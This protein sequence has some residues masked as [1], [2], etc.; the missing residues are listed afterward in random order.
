MLSEQE[1]GRL[2]PA[3][4]G[5]GQ[6]R[7]AGASALYG[8]PLSFDTLALYYNK[9]NFSAAPPADTTALLTVARGLT[10]TAS[11]PPTWGLALNLGLDRTIGYLYAFGGRVFDTQSSLVLGSDGRAGA[12]AWLRWLL[13]LQDDKRILASTD[14]ISVDSALMTRQALMTIDWAHALGVYRELWPE[15]LGVAAL[16]RLSAA[17]Q[18]PQAYVQS[19]VIVLNA[20]ASAAERQAAVA[21][22]R[23]L[24]DS[25][26]QADLLRAGRQPALGSLNL[27]TVAGLAPELRAAA[28]V[29]RA[30]AEQGQPMP[31]SRQANQLVWGALSDMQANVLRRL[32]GPDQAISAA[33][34]LLRERLGAPPGP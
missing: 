22:M 33:D 25:P 8:L 28:A 1:L 31:N 17:D 23:Y 11:R 3:A 2:I 12:A 24:I 18:P 30:Q 14:G 29:F 4:L 7:T 26:A 34:A 27:D 6:V 16:P 21:F 15:S 32:I 5:G 10:D 19:D 20:R 9:A 13:E